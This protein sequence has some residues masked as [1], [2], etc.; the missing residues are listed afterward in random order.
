[1][2]KRTALLAAAGALALVGTSAPNAAADGHGIGYYGLWAT[3]VNVREMYP[4]DSCWDYP[5]PA[6]CPDVLGQVGAPTQVFVRCQIPGQPVGGNPYW[7]VVE[8]PG[9]SKYGVMASYYLD[10]S[11]NWID[12]VPDHCVWSGG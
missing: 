8:V 1:M 11:S 3:G 5:S 6:N 4:I 10:N 7:V 9:W 12:G 2:R